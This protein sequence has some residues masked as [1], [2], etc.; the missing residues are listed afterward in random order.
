MASA[1][2]PQIFPGQ[3]TRGVQ[4]NP[5]GGSNQQAV[6]RTHS[7]PTDTTSL[8]AQTSGDDHRVID[9]QDAYVVPGPILQSPIL[10]LAAE[11]VDD[12]ERVR[13]ANVERLRSLTSIADGGFGLTAE[14]PDVARLAALVD[15]LGGAEE[16]AV[17]S[18]QKV[19]RAHPLGAWCKATAGI[20]EKQLAR[21]LAVIGDPYWNPPKRRPR[22]VSE[23]WAYCGLHVVHFEGKCD[24][25]YAAGAGV[26]PAHRKGVQG[27]WN[28][29]ARMRCWL[30]ATQIVK[31]PTSPYRSVYDEARAKY[32]DMLHVHPC[33]RCGPKGEPAQPGTPISAGHQHAR[34]VRF[35]AKRVLRDLWRESARLH[36]QPRA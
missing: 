10:G 15:Y 29:R 18:L 12:L 6:A 26:A 30:I 5:A 21:L 17:K 31:T 24:G 28:D 27:D 11:V 2:L 23:L 35:V 4:T 22:T 34:A 8:P 9:N 1:L 20:G 7:V 25:Q 3:R 13:K 16:V 14:H 32:A 19:M 36:E 33:A